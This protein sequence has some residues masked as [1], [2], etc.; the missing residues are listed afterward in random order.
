MAGKIISEIKANLEYLSGVERKIA[1]QIIADPK[2][3]T[4]YS[5][6][7]LSEEAGVSQGS[8][9]NFANKFSGGGFSN[10]KLKIAEGLSEL[11]VPAFSDV[12]SSDSVMT[13][14][15]KVTASTEEALDSVAKLNGEDGLKSAAEM[16]LKAKKVEIYGVYRSA[17]V[18]TDFY[19]QLLQ[20]GIPVSS[21]S[22]VLSCT[23]SAA[24]L[25]SGSVVVAVSSSGKTKDIIDA[26]K[27]AKSRGVKIVGITANRNSPLAN[28]SD[29]VLTAPASGNSIT[30]WSGEV[31]F[32]QMLITDTICDYLR[33][34]IDES[35]E[36]NYFMVSDILSSHSIED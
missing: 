7:E 8:I 28:M 2:K 14:L 12:E 31:R 22:D 34:R 19:Y 26:V 36:K 27:M 30:R 9:I 20:L 11:T 17:V 13:V 18:A 24:M 21:E 25:D 16:I 33:S 32:S 1:E 3:F 35:G 29:I 10:L 15:R 23:L 5:M 6:A 4:T